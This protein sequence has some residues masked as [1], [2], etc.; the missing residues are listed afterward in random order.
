MPDAG[1][2]INALASV[3][4][5]CPQLADK[6]RFIRCGDDNKPVMILHRDKCLRSQRVAFDHSNGDRLWAR[7]PAEN[8]DYR[9]SAIG[10]HVNTGEIV[11]S[12]GGSFIDR[13]S[14][15]ASGLD[16][17]SER[18]EGFLGKRGGE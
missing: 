14:L 12:L 2:V 18:R 1:P 10:R 7:L 17:V 9:L 5:K 3:G 4:V 15:R 13:K 8:A 11:K 16:D 6:R